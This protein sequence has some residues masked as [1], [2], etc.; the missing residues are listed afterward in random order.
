MKRKDIEKLYDEKYITRE[1]RDKL[2]KER[3]YSDKISDSI[4]TF[5]KEWDNNGWWKDYPHY[6]GH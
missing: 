1:Q 3:N 5:F 6:H 4:S 2:L